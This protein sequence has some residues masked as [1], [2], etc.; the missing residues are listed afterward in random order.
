LAG[1][2]DALGEDFSCPNQVAY[3]IAADFVDGAVHAKQ[4][5]AEWRNVYRNLREVV[6]PTDYEL[7]KERQQKR[8]RW[9]SSLEQAFEAI[10]RHSNSLPS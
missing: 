9:C 3:A 10:G 8:K 2:A 6:W 7:Q 1:V 5:E 4:S